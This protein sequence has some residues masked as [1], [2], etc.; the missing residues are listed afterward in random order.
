M[1]APQRQSYS[2]A[3]EGSVWIFFDL[4]APGLEESMHKSVAL[5]RRLW[6]VENEMLT[7]DHVI[8]SISPP[9]P[10]RDPA[11]RACWEASG[12]SV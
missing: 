10:A 12:I 6:D 2:N 3:E 7:P 4:R 9:D 5:W 11:K 1:I 8:I